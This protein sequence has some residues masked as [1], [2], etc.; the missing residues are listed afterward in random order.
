M[1]VDIND[2]SWFE[3]DSYLCKK[4]RFVIQI[5]GD[6]MEPTID[7]YD[8]VVCEYH[9]HS[10]NSRVVIMQLGV[11]SFIDNDCAVKRLKEDKRN[12]IFSSDNEKYDEIIVSKNEFENDCPMIG[13]VIYNL[14]KQE[15]V[16]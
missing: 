2:V 3:I 12:W 16:L 11:A 13:E 9:R 10:Y 4:K 5:I 8:F 1:N 6:S 14:T 15:K 7:K